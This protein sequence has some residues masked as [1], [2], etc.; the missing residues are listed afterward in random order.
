[1]AT[2]LSFAALD[3][4]TNDLNVSF[5]AGVYTLVDLGGTPVTTTVAGSASRFPRDGDVRRRAPS[6]AGSRRPR[7]RRHDHARRRHR[8]SRRSLAVRA[9]MCSPAAAAIDTLN[10]GADA[11]R[12]DGGRGNDTST[13]TRA[14]TPSSAAPAPPATTSSPAARAS[15]SPTT[16]SAV[17]QPACCR[18]TAW[19]TTGRRPR[20]DNIKT[21]VEN[22]TGGA[23]N[24]ALLGGAPANVLVGGPGVDSLDG[25]AANDVL[26][27]GAGRRLAHRRRGYRHGHLRRPQHAGDGHARRPLRRRRGGRGR[28][29][30]HDVETAIGGSDAD[31]SSGQ[32][33]RRHALRRCWRRHAAR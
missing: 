7:P 22:V 19:P 10:G 17:G 1:M 6:R 13:A 27:G 24:D 8:G 21:D 30:P 20:L 18:S 23:G 29:D 32:P 5:A 16:R 15:T 26:D 14:T 2:T 28:H 31:R 25:E 33:A 9:T 4:E 3:G 11:D 12:L